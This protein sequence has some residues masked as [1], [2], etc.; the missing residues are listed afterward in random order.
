MFAALPPNELL[1]ADLAIRRHHHADRLAVDLRH[2]CLQ[3]APRVDA[4][5]LGG[6]KADA[7][8]VGIVVVSVERE[9]DAQSGERQRRA[10][11]S[12]HD[13]AAFL[14]KTSS[15]PPRHAPETWIFGKEAGWARPSRLSIL[16]S[17]A[18]T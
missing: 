7:V 9:F 14:N 1:H 15:D 16:R 13:A 2:Q 10:G 17:E 3:H 18:H 11:G 12:G 4:E 8:G 6:L 5:R